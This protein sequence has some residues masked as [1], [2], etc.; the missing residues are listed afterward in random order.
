MLWTNTS[1]RGGGWTKT[2]FDL[3]QTSGE[4]LK[5]LFTAAHYRQ[6]NFNLLGI[7]YR[8]VTSAR[9][10]DTN[11]DSHPETIAWRYAGYVDNDVEYLYYAGAWIPRP[12]ADL[13]ELNNIRLQSDS[14]DVNVHHTGRYVYAVKA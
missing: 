6:V 10:S 13:L 11:I 5:L 1:I 14:R 7:Q 8:G 3:N 9:A 12:N 4:K 2:L